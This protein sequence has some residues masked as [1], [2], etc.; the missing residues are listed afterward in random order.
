M[1][2]HDVGRGRGSLEAAMARIKVP[3][4]AIG[5]WSD[6]LY[7][8]YQQKQI[9][10]LLH[11]NGTPAEYVEIDSPH[12]HD[13]FLLDLDQVGGAVSTFLD[14]VEKGDRR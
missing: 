7:P 13:S 3:T 1:D 5:I 2:L 10:E 9:R 8:S 4:L 14:D 12:G 6:Q 11:S